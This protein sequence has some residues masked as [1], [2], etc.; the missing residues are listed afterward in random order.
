MTRSGLERARQVGDRAGSHLLNSLHCHFCGWFFRVAATRKCFNGAKSARGVFDVGENKASSNKRRRHSQ[1]RFSRSLT[2][3]KTRQLGL[4]PH[5]QR[6]IVSVS[7]RSGPRLLFK[8]AP[9]SPTGL[10]AL[11][12]VTRVPFVD[13]IETTFVYPPVFLR[14]TSKVTM[15]RS[16]TS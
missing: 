7:L 9:S 12:L 8:R 10:V 3:C 16:L 4:V 5:S 15:M 14:W 13:P 6:L 2:T 1:H 11:L